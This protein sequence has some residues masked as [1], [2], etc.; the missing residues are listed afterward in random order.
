MSLKL[1]NPADIDRSFYPPPPKAL[2]LSPEALPANKT[3]AFSW[4]FIIID[5]IRL[6]DNK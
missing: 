5:I 3:L 1:G 4:T 6:P 2:Q